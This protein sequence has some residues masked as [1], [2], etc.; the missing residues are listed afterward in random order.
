MLRKKGLPLI[1]SLVSIQFTNLLSAYDFKKA[2]ELFNKRS[3]SFGK[4]SA[5]HEAYEEMTVKEKL[6]QEDRIYAFSQMAR[7]DLYR[8]AMLDGVSNSKRKEYLCHRRFSTN[9]AWNL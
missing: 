8:G 2:D 7:L 1:L 3:E 9:N 5:A 4:A 6:S